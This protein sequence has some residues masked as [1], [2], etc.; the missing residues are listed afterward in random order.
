MFSD[1]QLALLEAFNKRG[2]R[3]LIVGL[4]AA[5]L[6]G[7][8]VVTQDVDLWFEDLGNDNFQDAVKAVGGFYVSPGMAGLNPPMLG[9]Q[10]FRLFDLVTSCHGL[11]DFKTEYDRAL[12]VSI[13]DVPIKLLPLDR[14]IA[15]KQAADRDKDRAVLPILRTTLDTIRTRNGG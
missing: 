7:A 1:K 5:V 9:P 2:V 6:Q 15:S 11:D 12:S 14:I 4:G 10:E 8:H 13:R 3:F